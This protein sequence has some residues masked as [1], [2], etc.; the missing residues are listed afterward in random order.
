MWQ[1]VGKVLSA[2]DSNCEKDPCHAADQNCA[3]SMRWTCSFQASKW[4]LPHL[5]SA[6]IAIVIHDERLPMK[7]SCTREKG[8]Q[9]LKIKFRENSLRNAHD[10]FNVISIDNDFVKEQSYIFSFSSSFRSPCSITKRCFWN[11]TTT[12]QIGDILNIP[13]VK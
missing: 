10:H 5:H 4:S 8:I 12:L 2:S 1:Y 3:I 7:S 13:M 11:P 9:T 6:I